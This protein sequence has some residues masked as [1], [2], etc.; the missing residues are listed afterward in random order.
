MRIPAS[1]LPITAPVTPLTGHGPYGKLYG[2]PYTL[3]C[4]IEPK[5]ELI[6]DRNGEE[7]VA[8]ARLFAFPEATLKPEDK[9]EWAGQHYEV[10][11]VA[12]MPWV[13]GSIHHLECW[14]SPK[15]GG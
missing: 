4:R 3:K 10:A 5:R 2:T 13:D 12:P 8:M 15:G 11:T 1:L 7:I 6:R 14:L 9:I